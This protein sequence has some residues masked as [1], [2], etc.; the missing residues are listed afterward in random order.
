MAVYEGRIGRKGKNTVEYLTLQKNFKYLAEKLQHD[1]PVVVAE[2]FSRGVI[3]SPK[4]SDSTDKFEKASNLMEIVLSAVESDA[5]VY[6]TFLDSLDTLGKIDI[7]ETLTDY[8]DLQAPPTA[9]YQEVPSFMI[10]SQKPH[11]PRRIEDSFHESQ[12]SASKRNLPDHSTGFAK[13]KS[14]ESNASGKDSAF[15]EDQSLFSTNDEDYQNLEGVPDKA[16]DNTSSSIDHPMST[17]AADLDTDASDWSSPINF[18]TPNSHE[19]AS[20]SSSYLTTVKAVASSEELSNSKPVYGPT[21]VAVD[22]SH[23]YERAAMEMENKQQKAEIECLKEQRDLKDEEL[24]KVKDDKQKALMEQDRIVKEK[25]DKILKLQK[26]HK[27]KDELIAKLESDKD[28]IKT[29]M[30][31][32]EQ[33]CQKAIDMQKEAEQKTALVLE[34]FREKEALLMKEVHERELIEKEL[35]ELKFEREQEMRKLE[36]RKHELE[37]IELQL[38]SE[39]EKQKI[40][41]DEKLL[42]KTKLLLSKVS[43]LLTPKKNL[44]KISKN[45]LKMIKKIW[46][47]RWKS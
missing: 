35:I 8:K 26:D 19:E 18:S 23:R 6:K 14:N 2:L 42:R 22:Y 27:C 15:S 17:S 41:K 7:V 38:R 28:K 10:D 37:K 29:E 25:D 20:T 9:A 30:S 16:K 44:L 11:L 46:R 34:Q 12:P 39:I 43:C 32:L 4:V 36:Q 31:E 21:N 47:W 1:L 3:P 24:R 5:K 13:S 33:K 45:L 40:E